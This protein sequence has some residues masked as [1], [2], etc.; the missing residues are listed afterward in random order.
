MYVGLAQSLFERLDCPAATIDLN[1]QYRMNQTIADLANHLTYKV[2][3]LLEGREGGGDSMSVLD[4]A[5]SSI[6]T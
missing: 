1:I 5:S 6:Y 4:L 2:H 3:G